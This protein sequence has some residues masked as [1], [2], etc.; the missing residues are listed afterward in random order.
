[1]AGFEVTGVD[2]NKDHKKSYCTNGKSFV[3]GDVL[4]LST[5][6]IK[7][8]DFVWAS[9]PCQVHCSIIPKSQREKHEERWKA[10]GRHL[11]LIPA[12]R[13]LLERAGVP[14]V[15]ENVIGAKKHLVNPVQLCGTQFGLSVYRH[16]Y[17][18]TH[19]FQIKP[20]PKCKHTNS[21]IGAL[22][23]GIKPVRSECYTSEDLAALKAGEA[24]EGFEAR[25]VRFPSHGDRID[26]IYLPVTKTTQERC[27]E[28][29]KRNFARSIKE[30][31]R[32]TEQLRALTEAE[33]RGE[34]ERYSAELRARLPEGATQMWPVYGT[35]KSRGSNKEWSEA[36]GGLDWLDR[37]ELR[38]AIPP[39]YAKWIGGSFLGTV[40]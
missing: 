33:S 31:L 37:N 38:E 23:G 6:F 25:E 15:I 26:H 21:G 5:Q 14:F 22:S 10:E 18:E 36:M 27:R 7:R 19:G 12:T 17:F 35:T 2:N 40:E 1:M 16:R 9:P 29:Y 3:E 34:R 20:L 11:D 8:F 32:I 30:A 28:L 24:P 39:A 4:K 13:A